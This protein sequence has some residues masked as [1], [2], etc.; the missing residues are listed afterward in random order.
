MEQ[1]FNTCVYVLFWIKYAQADL[2][3][4]IIMNMLPKIK[5]YQNNNLIVMIKDGIVYEG[6]MEKNDTIKM[7]K[8]IHEN[9]K[10]ICFDPPRYNNVYS[11]TNYASTHKKE[12]I[13]MHD[14]IK[15]K[16]NK[17]FTLALTKSKYLFAKGY[18]FTGQLG[19]GDDIN[20]ITFEK[21]NLPNVINFWIGSYHNCALTSDGLYT[22]GHNYAQPNR[23]EVH[24]Y[25]PTL[26][27][28]SGTI[29]ISCGMFHTIALCKDDAYVWGSNNY[30]QI[31]HDPNNFVRSPT[32]LNLD[33]VINV[34]AGD[35]YSIILTKDKKI[36]IFGSNSSLIH[37]TS[38][39]FKMKRSDN[40]ALVIYDT[41][42]AQIFNFNTLQN[43]KIMLPQNKSQQHEFNVPIIM[44][45]TTF[46]IISIITYIR[47]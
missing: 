29:K 15:L 35:F 30:G 14:I 12:I 36:H 40:S 26:V 23:N 28:I 16:C 22:W 9:V 42:R 39:I 43:Y 11:C 5:I 17:T 8:T 2:R 34:C 37:D 24:N 6:N 1:L 18:N 47:Q 21:I 7:N 27:Q 4:K 25:S 20:R 44:L 32:R 33:N 45:F 31:Y 3:S 41:G 10:S 13:P 46:V 38:N 19:L